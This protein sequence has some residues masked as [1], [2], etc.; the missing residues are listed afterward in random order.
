MPACCI[1]IISITNF[2][3][4]SLSGTYLECDKDTSSLPRYGAWSD[5]V[6]SA[7]ELASSACAFV[8]PVGSDVPVDPHVSRYYRCCVIPAV[9]ATLTVIRYTTYVSHEAMVIR[10]SIP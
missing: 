2:V 3:T 9:A 6:A 8:V 7:C 10:I 1:F 5:S 4:R